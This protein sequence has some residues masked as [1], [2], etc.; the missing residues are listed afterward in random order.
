VVVTTTGNFHSPTVAPAI[1]H[2]T[3]TP[4]SH[5][6]WLQVTSGFTSASPCSFIQILGPNNFW[7]ARQSLVGQGLPYC[8]G[9]TIILRH[10]TL[11]RTALGEWSARRTDLS[12]WQHSKQT[13]VLLVGFEPVIPATELPQTH[14]L[15]RVSTGI[16]RSHHTHRN[17][18]VL[19][20]SPLTQVHKKIGTIR[21]FGSR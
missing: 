17:F 19:S 5:I 6:D 4:N 15:A 13:S 8:R 1:P 11:G 16:G 14:A 2:N 21:D 18:F 7:G 10:T 12:T 20:L 3:A 9:F